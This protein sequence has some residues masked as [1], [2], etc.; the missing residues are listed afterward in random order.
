[1]SF[2]PSKCSV[3]GIT[4]G[5]KK[6]KNVFQSTYILHNKVL[7]VTDASKYMYLGVKVTEDLT[8]SRH[9]SEV[10]GKANRSLG[11]L[12]RNFR[13]CTKEVKATTHTTMVRPVLDY[14]VTH[15][16]YGIHINKETSNFLSKFNDEPPDMCTMFIPIVHLV[17]SQRW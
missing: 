7:E 4:S 14:G 5:K 15:P 17:V 11:F 16:L 9:N 6:K 1:M 12:P 8:W 3:I 13:Q 2:N 10:A